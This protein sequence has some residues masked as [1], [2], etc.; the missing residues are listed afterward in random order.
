MNSNRSLFLKVFLVTD[1]KTVTNKVSLN[2]HFF[3]PRAI[4]LKI[5]I[6]QRIP[7]KY[8]RALSLSLRSQ[9]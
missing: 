5:Y 8:L 3:L 1:E 9:L 4:S 2:F 7:F 6:Y